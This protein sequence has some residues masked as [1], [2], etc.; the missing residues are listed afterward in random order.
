M[1]RFDVIVVGGGFAGLRAARDLTDVGQSVLVLEARDRL[2]GRAWTARF[3]GRDE[4]VE[5]GGTWIAPRHSPYVR[6]E[7]ERYGLQLTTS[8]GGPIDTRWNFDGTARTTFPIEGGDRYALERALFSLIDASHRID[9]TK[10]R[11][12]ELRDL[13]V[14][15]EEYVRGLD[16][17]ASVRDYLY[18]WA[19]LG[20]GALPSEWSALRVLS[21]IAAM[22]NSALA[23]YQAV[24]DRFA[25]GATDVVETIARATKGEIELETPVARIDQ[26]GPDVVVTTRAGEELAAEAVIVATPLGTWTDIGFRPALPE[27][28]LLPAAR[29]HC[30]RMKKVW[31]ITQGVPPRLFATGWGTEF[32]ECFV[33]QEVEDGQLVLGMLAPPS[34]LDP[35]DLDAVTAAIRQFA[36]E[37]TV[38]ATDHHDWVSDPYAKG[39]WMV[40]PPGMLTRSHEAVRRP[41]GRVAFAGA[42]LAVGWIGWIEGAL[43]TGA[44][45]AK[46]ALDMRTG[47]SSA[48]SLRD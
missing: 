24:S 40:N 18:M 19:A 44:R 26:T 4:L 9:V 28:K 11:G 23:L 25:K 1:R 35:T 10:P 7:I 45:A 12:P 37:G 46:W 31:M 47:R 15:V 14:S 48:Y 43:E 2:G 32:V 42:D 38:L 21:L 30:G 41:E 27:D 6:Q 39:T 20:S 36:P 3:K 5:H 8:H 34:E 17:P 22:G 29:K 16:L 33:E 13:D